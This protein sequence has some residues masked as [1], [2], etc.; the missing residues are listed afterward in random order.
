MSSSL[1]RSIL[2]ASD[3]QFGVNLWDIAPPM[4]PVGAVSRRIGIVGDFPWGAVN[5]PT[6]CL[7]YQDILAAICPAALGS[8]ILAA[9]TAMAAFLGKTF[10]GPVVL[11]RINATD[12]AAEILSYTVTGGTIVATGNYKGTALAGLTVTWAAATDADSTH[13]DLTVAIGTSYSVTYTNVT[14]TNITS[15][16]DPY[17]TWTKGSAPSVL[18]A[19]AASVTA[20]TAGLAGTAVA[21]DYVGSSSSNVGIQTF[22]ASNQDVDVLFVA[23]CPSGLVAAVNAGLKTYADTAGKSGLAVLCSV[24][25]QSAAT[26]STYAATYSNAQSKTVGCWPR[27]KLIDGRSASLPTLTVDGNAFMAVAMASVDPWDSPEGV[28]SAPY[29][30]AITG[31]ETDG[32][33]DTAYAA[34]QAGGMSA[35]FL[36]STLGPIIR[37]AVTTNLTSGQ[38]DI[39]RSLYRRYLGNQ[40]AAYAVHYIGVALQVNLTTQKLG[41]KVSPL[42]AAIRAFCALEQALEHINGYTV[43][44]FSGNVTADIDAGNWTIL[45]AIDTY[46][47]LRKLIIGT[48]IGSTVV[49]TS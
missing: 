9:S 6:L 14:L 24:P 4:S 18:P 47:P 25:S 34:I 2:K 37:G 12:A 46:A 20:R 21:G 23:E 30:T 33:S 39:I 28:N 40:V 8:A 10:P 13:R 19:A 11:C 5:T 29:L 44:P 31:L 16:G 26:A 49:T 45:T 22:Y 32:S 42:V 17:I 15:L 35:F 27:V 7:S 1:V 36:E 43:D 3:A 41:A 48:Q 38:T